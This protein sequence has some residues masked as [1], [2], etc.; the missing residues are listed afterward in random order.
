MSSTGTGGVGGTEKSSIS[1][2]AY[3]PAA[4]SIAP[5]SRSMTPTSI[6]ILGGGQLGRMLA[7][8]G[9]PLGLNFRF[10]DPD[11]HC[12]AAHFGTLVTGAFDDP[13]ALDRFTEG[14]ECVTFEFENVPAAV[15]R[16]LAERVRIAPCAESLATGQD[17]A[18]EKRFFESC[19]VPVEAWATVDDDDTLAAA[20]DRVGVPGVLKTRRLG[21]DGKGQRVVRTSADA[22]PAFAALHRAA[23]TYEK[24]VPF[25]RELSVI[26][27]RSA[28]GAFRHWPISENVHRAGILHSTIAPASIDAATE[29]TLAAHARRV[30]ER[31]DHVG[32]LAIEFF[33]KGGTLLANEM[34]PRVHN[35]GHWTIDGAVTSQFENHLRAICG[36][37]LGATTAHGHT[38]MLNLVG[39]V[40]PTT[41]LAAEPDL[42]IHLYGKSA[43]PGRKLGHLNVVAATAAAARERLRTLE[44]RFTPG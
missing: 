37:P 39:E 24:L 44:A 3:A 23:C 27:V 42:K 36:L 26:A 18:M 13:T 43:R 34:A 2:H 7:L 10:L 17:R 22:K 38:V 28:D 29:A 31:L 6:G 1:A 16:R 41:A 30:M 12:P 11:P 40:P 4:S 14:V 25:T 35:S 32:V 33:D 5:S 15:V 9:A 21:Y 20:L 19:G 8:A